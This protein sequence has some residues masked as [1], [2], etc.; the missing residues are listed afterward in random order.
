MRW[1]KYL[2]GALTI[3]LAFTILWVDHLTPLGV[4][5]GM[6]YSVVILSALFTGS[7]RF[8][9]LVSGIS[10]VFLA[11][12]YALSEKI[13][14]PAWI[15]FTNRGMSLLTIFLT[16]LL[17]L[18]L[19]SAREKV[20]QH[21]SELEVMSITDITTGVFNRRHLNDVL[22]TEYKRMVREG[23]TL[24]ILMIDVDYFKN[25][26]D[27]LGH[28]MGDDCLKLVAQTLKGVLQR[29]ADVLGRYGAGDEFTAVLPNT[30]KE[31]ALALA[32]QMVE[33]VSSL[34]ISHPDSK[35]ACHVTVS[36]GG[37]SHSAGE[38]GDG[39]VMSLLRLADLAMYRS[40]QSGRNCA[41][42]LEEEAAGETGNTA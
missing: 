14:V 16:A 13:G 15:V 28:Q 10:L 29:P 11:A 38:E 30:D 9:Y 36:I 24:S 1:P 19:Q 12:G 2:N 8:I 35:A 3:L 32:G 20:K 26:N 7:R 21:Q 42:I 22:E 23:T 6:L 41:V 34:K 39:S 27:N 40:K 17:V 4:A 25:Y 18:K 37:A 33:A 31:G 5:D